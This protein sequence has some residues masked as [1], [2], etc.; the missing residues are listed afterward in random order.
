[1]K[2][3]TTASIGILLLLP[4][5]Q[6]ASSSST[7]PTL[8]A[9][10]KVE[11]SD[12]SSVKKTFEHL[13][14]FKVP[15]EGSGDFTKSNVKKLFSGNAIDI[16]GASF[17]PTIR[18][19]NK[20]SFGLN[21]LVD[22]SV[23]ITS[24]FGCERFTDNLS[25]IYGVP[26]VQNNKSLGN[27]ENSEA[28]WRSNKYDISSSCALFHME[29]GNKFPLIWISFRDKKEMPE[30]KP[31]VRLSCSNTLSQK[32]NND[33]EK[34]SQ[35]PPITIIID[36]TYK[37]ISSSLR[38]GEVAEFNDS[39]IST[40]LEE[41]TEHGLK[42]DLTMRLDRITGTY[43]NQVIGSKEGLKVVHTN[44]GSCTKTDQSKKF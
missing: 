20:G 42:L 6:S 18:Q 37:E 11:W 13:T 16:S 24:D 22:S 17:H 19:E 36:T 5:S 1:M 10:S 23:T 21:L 2:L 33:D 41:T 39:F 32:I 30:L 31:A 15:E 38:V 7:L 35:Q 26:N 3:V 34:I 12:L 25:A 29:N 28:Q 8:K 40:K 4:L 9:V 27:V 44:W 43:K 14:P